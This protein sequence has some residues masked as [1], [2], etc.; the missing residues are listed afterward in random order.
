MTRRPL[1]A[2]AA[3]RLGHRRRADVV[4][5]QVDAAA[6]C[7]AAHLLAPAGLRVVD[8]A[9]DARGE[10]ALALRGGR[11]RG[12]HPGAREPGERDRGAPH[13]RSGCGHEHGLARPEA[14][15]RE[16]HVVRGE[17]RPT[18]PR[19]PSR[20]RRRRRARTGFARATR[21]APHSLRRGSRP[22]RRSRHRPP[23]RLRGSTGSGRTRSRSGRR[24]W[25]RARPPRRRPRPRSPRPRR[26]SRGRS[27]ASRRTRGRRPGAPRCRA[28]SRPRPRHGRA[29]RPA[30]APR[31][32]D[33]RAPAPPAR[34]ASA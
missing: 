8:D 22:S 12:D 4:D 34:R 31:R 2:S 18:P 29:P 5:D 32:V 10:G 11:G 3:E 26:R 15:A 17:V 9:V 19:R 7:Q 13:S 21:S 23:R 25:P 30:P 28:G 20:T 16:Q 33:R 14:G 27:G 1:F 24:P 6:S